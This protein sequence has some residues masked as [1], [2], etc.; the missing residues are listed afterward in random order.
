MLENELIRLRALEISDVDKLYEWENNRAN[1]RVSHTIA[2][3][4]KHILIDYIGSVSDV[5]TDKQLR[6]IIEGVESG[7]A[8][9]TVDLFDCDFKNKRAGLG[10]L[11]GDEADRGKGIASEAMRLMLR[12][13]FEVLG[14][15]QVYSNILEDNESSIMLFEKFGFEKI[16]LKKDWVYAD[17]KYWNEW[18][19]HKINPDEA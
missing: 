13:C 5:Y 19:L 14:L 7:L 9:G 15:H 10:I 3:Y 4:S 18:L 11:V 2:P 1:W 16:A 12:Y 8:L 17:G 6:L